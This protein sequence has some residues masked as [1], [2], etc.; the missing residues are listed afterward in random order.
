ML[1]ALLLAAPLV[2]APALAGNLESG[3]VAELQFSEPE[4]PPSLYSLFTGNE[5]PPTLTF[6]LPDNYSPDRQY[7]LLVYIPGYHGGPKGNIGNAMTIAGDED[8]VVASLPLFK[9]ALNREEIS[10][11]LLVSIE[12]APTISHAYESM[13]GKLFKLVPNID[14][15]RSAMVGFSNGALTVAVLVS[16][17]DQFVLS[18]FKH[19]CLVDFGMFHLTDL[20]KHRSRDRRYLVLSGDK[21]EM[22]RDLKIRGGQLLQDSWRLLGVDLSFHVMKDTGHEF[23]YRQMAIVGRWLRYES[24]AEGDVVPPGS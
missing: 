7:P 12:D 2:C 22:G 18:H 15:N 23:N 6:R 11:G 21:Q 3:K 5:F 4:I 9:S 24:F 10:G 13:L 19:Y 16:S 20:H 8:W 14:L 17:H 1:K